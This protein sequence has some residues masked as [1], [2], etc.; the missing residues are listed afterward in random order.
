[1]KK[2]TAYIIFAI[3]MSLWSNNETFA[4]VP[5]Y[6]FDAINLD[7]I[8]ANDPNPVVFMRQVYVTSEKSNMSRRDRRRQT[9]LTRN[10]KKAYPYAKLLSS[11]MKDIENNMQYIK[12]EKDRE[13][14]V[15]IREKAFRKH[16]EDEIKKLT[17]SQGLLLI[18][19]IDRET[20]ETSFEI[21]K[22]FRGG[23]LAGTYQA[24]AR[25]FGHNLKVDYEPEGED[26]EI[27][28]LVLKYENGQL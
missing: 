23:L 13:S 9:R 12:D 22:E 18:K 2:I 24:I 5:D 21:I 4:Q 28:M 19:L 25:I 10:F 8:I 1:M 20:G 11:T 7:S 15:K 6:Y 26:K 16:Y 14:Y 17:I 27:E 3:S